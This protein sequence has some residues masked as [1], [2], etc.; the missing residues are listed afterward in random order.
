MRN[1]QL[2]NNSIIYFVTWKKQK[3]HVEFFYDL[4][5]FVESYPRYV[6][7]KISQE[8][9]SGIA[10][11]EDEDVRIE[12]REIVTA[13]KPDFAPMFFWDLRYDKIDWAGSS[14][15]VIQRILERGMPEH[16][17]ELKRF[18]GEETIIIALKEKITYL[19]DECI[20]EASLFFNLKKEEMLCYRR[21]QSQP[22]LWR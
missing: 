10:V 16:W 15:T 7:S 9:A 11:F 20:D 17:N 19:P 13:P 8:L 14:T 12:E 1:G 22:K 18:Y 21:K 2:S 5:V 4:N 3:R 6:L